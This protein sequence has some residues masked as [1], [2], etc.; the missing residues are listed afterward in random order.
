MWDWCGICPGTLKWDCCERDV[1]AHWWGDGPSHWC[2]TDVGYTLTLKWDWCGMSRHIDEGRPITWSG[3]DVGCPGTLTRDAPALEVGLMW[4]V[5]AHWYAFMTR[6]DKNCGGYWQLKLAEYNLI[7]KFNLIRFKRF[8]F[9]GHKSKKATSAAYPIDFDKKIITYNQAIRVSYGNSGELWQ[10]GWVV[11]IRVS[12]GNSGE[13]WQ[14]GWVV[15]I[16]G[17]CGN[18]VSRFSCGNSGVLLYFGWIVTIWAS[19]VVRPSSHLPVI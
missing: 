12:C 2:G 13:L 9:A 8:Y 18:S 7:L 3:T 10:F 14:F 19:S 1:T 4:D 6:N 17:C 16:R 15:A 11:A 5:P